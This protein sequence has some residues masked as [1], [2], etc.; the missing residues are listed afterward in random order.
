MQVFNLAVGHDINDK[1]NFFLSL[2]GNHVA[3]CQVDA[4]GFLKIS[5]LDAEAVIHHFMFH[6]VEQE[7]K[8]AKDILSMVMEEPPVNSIKHVLEP[9]NLLTTVEY[10][11]F[12]FHDTVA[13]KVVSRQIDHNGDFSV[14]AGQHEYLCDGL[15]KLY[16][17]DRVIKLLNS[18]PVIGE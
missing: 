7:N 8:I 4:M 3:T 9:I 13:N 10:F 12:A 5:K 17:V 2:R 14:T 18:I 6:G 15:S 1:I 11:I 16:N